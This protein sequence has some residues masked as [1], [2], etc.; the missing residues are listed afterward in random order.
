MSLI[1]I[2]PCDNTFFRDGHQFNFDV[3]NVIKSK[4]TPYPSVFFG[5]IF[6]AILTHNDS[7]RKNFFNNNKYD[8]ENI[9]KIGQ[10]YLFNEKNNKVY[11]KAP[12]DLFINSKRD[13]AFGKFTK[14]D[15]SFNSLSYEYILESSINIDYEKVSDKYINIRNIYDAYIKK[16]GI[17]IELLDEETI[18]VKN[19]KIGIGIDKTTKSV[20]QGKLYKTEQT[21]F[22]NNDWSYI[23]EYDIKKDYLIK[24]YSNINL[25]DLDKGYLKLGGENKVCK[26]KNIKNKD[27]EKFQSKTID[28]SNNIFKIVFTSETYFAENIDKYFKNIGLKILGMANDKPIYIGGYD[29]KTKGK[30]NGSARKM[31]KGYPSGTVLL[32]ETIN[33]Q[34]VKQ[35]LL[36]NFSDKMK[37]SR[38]FNKYV[39]LE[40]L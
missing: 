2:K 28:K 9:L 37:N 3:S 12:M 4:N 33:K 22:I 11:I 13:I 5:A 21:E 16:Q 35:Q 25:S 14:V 31:Y 23:V 27:I 24:N 38:G 1:N 15:N 19:Y 17:R 34:N 40:D 18:F 39:I 30:Q 10:V 6:T 36:N 29:M 32:V 7:F 20:E 26:F 8:H